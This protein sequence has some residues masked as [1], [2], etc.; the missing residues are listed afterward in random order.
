MQK[1]SVFNKDCFIP[2]SL[3]N[4]INALFLGN[5]LNAT[6]SSP[7][8]FTDLVAGDYIVYVE[9]GDCNETTAIITITEPNAQ[10]EATI[11]I[12]DVTCSGDDNGFVEITASGGTGTIQYAISPQLNQFFETNTFTNLAAGDYTVIVQDQ[13]GCYLTFNFT[14][15]NPDPVLITIV[16]DSLFPEL[17]D[18]DENGEQ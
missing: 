11:A 4:F 9:S 6:Q 16:P 10:L 7:G 12:N 2:S 3:K 8:Y 14:I 5:P 17:C 1:F 18:G 15:T 13:L